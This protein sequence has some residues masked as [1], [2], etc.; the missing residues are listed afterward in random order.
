M[1]RLTIQQLNEEHGGI[2]PSD[3][4]LVGEDSCPFPPAL[5]RGGRR[6]GRGARFAVL[7]AFVDFAL[8]EVTGAEV[9]VW[10]ILFRDTKVATGTART[11]QADLAR[12]A[13]VGVRTVRRALMAL[14]QKAL[15]Q[16]VH[17]GRLRTG[18]SVYRVRA[19][20]P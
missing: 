5:R 7:N 18:A 10:L 17:R 3:A 16:V 20:P 2:L 9:R 14:E 6:P 1:R 11:G 8:A 12:R 15:I 19:Q 13:G 4:V